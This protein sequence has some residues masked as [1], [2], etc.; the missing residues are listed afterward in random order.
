MSE[1]ASFSPNRLLPP[2]LRRSFGAGL[3]ALTVG[4]GSGACTG[5]GSMSLGESGQTSQSAA[6][7]PG[8]GVSEGASYSPDLAKYGNYAGTVADLRDDTPYEQ[9]RW[10]TKLVCYQQK[11]EPNTSPG[12]W[13]DYRKFLKR[14]Y[15]QSWQKVNDSGRRVEL[16]SD[17]TELE[18]VFSGD[19]SPEGC[20]AWAITHNI[21]PTNRG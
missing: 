2:R 15:E 8:S 10:S 4:V 13:R 19:R 21:G 17:F 6:P 1:Q 7:F 9:L 12:Q 20:E 5:E 11:G 14:T 16:P 18:N 3:L